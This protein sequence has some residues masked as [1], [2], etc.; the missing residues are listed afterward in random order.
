MPAQQGQLSSTRRGEEVGRAFR[1]AS[2]LQGIDVVRSIAAAA[3]AA[4]HF[5][6]MEG[7]AD[8]HMSA[9]RASLGSR[10]DFH[11]FCTAVFP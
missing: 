5:V 2:T 9:R 1:S 6:I 7:G 8:I 11:A 4:A 10:A 3:A